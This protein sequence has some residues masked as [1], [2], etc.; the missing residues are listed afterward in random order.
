MK[1]YE[2]EMGGKENF[3]ERNY[4]EEKGKPDRYAVLM[5]LLIDSLNF[6]HQIYFK[7]NPFP[8]F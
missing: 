7:I 8:Q 1:S 2:V 4:E 6:I 3:V 5:Q